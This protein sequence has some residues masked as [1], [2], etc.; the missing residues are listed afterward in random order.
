MLWLVDWDIFHY[1]ILINQSEYTNYLWKGSLWVYWPMTRKKSKLLIYLFLKH[2]I[3]QW[4]NKKIYEYILSGV[5]NSANVMTIYVE[6][7]IKATSSYILT[8]MIYKVQIESYIWCTY[9]FKLRN[10]WH[11]SPQDCL[12]T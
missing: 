11:T 12:V 9:V 7:K 5:G 2:N 6:W 4:I 1:S 3:L 10:H 8:S